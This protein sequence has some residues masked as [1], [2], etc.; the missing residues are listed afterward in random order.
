M[1]IIALSTLAV[2]AASSA[3]PAT[4]GVYVNVENNGTRTGSNYTGSTTDAHLGYE[5]DVGKLGYY[6][7]GGPA[8]IHTDGADG[9]T[10]FS[11]KLGGNVNAT[12]RLSVYGEVSLITADGDDNNTLGSKI[13]TKFKF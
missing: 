11:G 4:A 10:Q 3:L 12:D 9:E 1:K 7:Q 8:F 13:G 6:I 5:G 2:I